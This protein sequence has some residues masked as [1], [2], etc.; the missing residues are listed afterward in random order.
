MLEQIAQLLQDEGEIVGAVENGEQLIGAALNL[1]P[2]LIVLDVSMSVINGIEVAHRLK[3]LGLRAKVIF[4]TMHEDDTFMTAATVAGALG[5]V[6]KHR[7]AIDLIP[8]V[9]KVLQGHPFA[10]PY[11]SME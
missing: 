1:N 8:A 11:L 9:R 4:V 2:D 6:F 3:T 5:Y 10:S 7:V